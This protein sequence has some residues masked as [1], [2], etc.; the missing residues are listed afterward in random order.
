MAPAAAE[1]APG[2]GPSAKTW[3]QLD[4]VAA[5]PKRLLEGDASGVLVATVVIILAIGAF[6]PDFLSPSQLLG[7]IQQNVYI[8]IMA[9]GMAFL[10]AML[11]I[12]LS[13]GSIFALTL[14]VA[15]LLDRGGM[16]PWLSAAL[17][18][19]LGA[20]LGLVNALL[21]QLIGIPAIVATLGTLSMYAGLALALAN[22]EQVTGLPINNP[23]FTI[24]GGDFLGVPVSIWVLI[25]VV[26]VLT[27][28]LRLTPFGY[29]VRAIGSN[30]EAARFSGI[31]IPR[32]RVQALVL[33]GLL[34]G[35]AG[36]LGVAFF[37][38]GD[39]TIGNGFEL[40]AIAAAVIGG[41][42][43]RGGSATVV[44]AVTGA[45]LLGMVSSGLIFFNV[46]LNW[47]SFATGATVI[48]AV[49][50][51]SLLRHRRQH[52]QSRIGL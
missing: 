11:E 48:V 30:P 41:T 22:G 51:D 39:P 47:T 20:L 32:V 25:V 4:Q 8:C 38:S 52:W 45:V 12:D 14:V 49:S 26:I 50:I 15:A 17:V 10:L 19:G 16:N 44:G 1:K 36:V 2:D 31:S 34:C 23:F 27:G 42:P 13:V 5:L 21:V 40:Q 43:L 6:H 33:V 3:G 24:V 18:L 28:L 7:V 35:L 46:P 29:R 9:A 37:N